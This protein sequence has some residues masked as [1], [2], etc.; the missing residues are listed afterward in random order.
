MELD[1][2]KSS[3]DWKMTTERK[4]NK[5]L[6]SKKQEKFDNLDVFTR[7]VREEKTKLKWRFEN[8]KETA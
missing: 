1:E 6:L 3:R 4:K 2:K 8:I 7:N 5:K